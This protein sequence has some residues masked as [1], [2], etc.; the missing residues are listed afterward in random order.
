MRLA[1][2]E[3]EVSVDAGNGGRLS[4][5]RI[6]GVELL[7][8]GAGFGSFPMVPWCGRVAEG[9]FRDGAEMRQLPLNNPPHAIHG[10]GREVPWKVVRAS[11]TEAVLSYELGDPWPYPGRVT[12]TVTL[13]EGALTLFLGIEAYESSFPAQA[14]WHPGSCAT[15]G[16]AGRVSGWSST[17]PGRRSAAATT[18]RPGGGPTR[19]PA[20]GTTASA[21]PRVST[22]RF[23]GPASWS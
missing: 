6:G 4:S 10:T 2:G 18:C 13:E 8:Q 1:A 7:R 21:C 17:R 5:L 16:R 22:S 19:S 23:S 11:A 15:S 3:A 12:Q 14:G 9:R 20:R